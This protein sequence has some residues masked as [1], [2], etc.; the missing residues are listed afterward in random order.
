MLRMFV[1]IRP[2][3]P[4]AGLRR[5]RS[6]APAGG[7]AATCVR[8][9]PNPYPGAQSAAPTKRKLRTGGAAFGLPL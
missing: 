1:A 5:Q 3:V 8:T 4:G 9:L 6:R 7:R 2:R